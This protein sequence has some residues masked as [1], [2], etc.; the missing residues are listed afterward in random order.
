MEKVRELISE[1]N[2]NLKQ[3]SSSQKD[4]VKVMKAMLNDKDFSVDIYGK[5]GVQGTYNPSVEMRSTIANIVSSVTKISKE[6]ANTCMD[7]YEFKNNDASAFVDLSKEYV[8]TYLDTGR[9]LSLGAR[10]DSDISLSR[11]IEEEG[12]RSYPKKIGEDANGKAIY[13]KANVLVPRHKGIKVYS[14]CP[15]YLKK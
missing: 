3:N 14:P 13:E 10:E 2:K 15:D 6:E 8:N 1:I 5:D 9:K 7:N 11:K 12:Y 4:E